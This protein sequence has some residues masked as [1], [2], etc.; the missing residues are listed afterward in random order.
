MRNSKLSQEN[1]N[2]INALDLFGE[3][4][5]AVDVTKAE[6]YL[7]LN[8]GVD[9]PKEKFSMLWEMIIEDNWS[10]ERLFRT[11]KWFLK[12]KKF[13]NWTTADWF[14][15]GIKIFP[16]SWYLQKIHEGVRSCDMQ[17]YRIDGKV[18]WKMKDNEELPFEKVG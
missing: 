9:Y 11:L 6:E 12:T 8:Y 7:K 2:G 3:K 10:N 14:E 5:S 18:F 13:P 17:G 1:P 15:Y 16:H 4:I